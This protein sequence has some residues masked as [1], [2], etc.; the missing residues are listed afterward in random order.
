MKQ[1]AGTA[2]IVRIELWHGLLLLA[3]ALTLGQSRFIELKALLLGGVFMGVNFF[4]LGFGILWVLPPLASKGRVTAGVSLLILKIIFFLS[5]LTLLFFRF[6]IDGLSFAL[7]V[8][9]LILAIFVEAV[10]YSFK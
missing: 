7:G 9:T 6:H 2:T 8:S 5:L 3:T 4:L 10:I 1:P